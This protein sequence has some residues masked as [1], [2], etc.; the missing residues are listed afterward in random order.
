MA[1][2]VSTQVFVPEIFDGVHARGTV[3]R[4]V[5]YP[6]EPVAANELLFE[7]R[8]ADTCAEILAPFAGTVLKIHA[9]EGDAVQAGTLL[10]HIR[11]A[12]GAATFTISG[13]IR[14]TVATR[15]PQTAAM[16][17]AAG[18]LV[19]PKL[20]LV[21]VL[22]GAITVL[23]ARTADVRR[24]DLRRR[25]L[26]VALGHLL[27]GTG[28]WA[29]WSVR[30]PWRVRRLC[31]R[32]VGLG[33]LAIALSTALGALLWLIEEGPNGVL[34]AARI[35]VVDHAGRAFAFFACAW[36]LYGFLA[37]PEPANAL[38]D[39]ARSSPAWANVAG[40]AAALIVVLLSA[41]LPNPSGSVTAVVADLRF[42][43]DAAR[44]WLE[45]RRADWVLSEVRAVGRCLRARGRGGWRRAAARTRDDGSVVVSVYSRRR[46]PSGN[47]SLGTLM[48]AL[49]NQLEPQNVTVVLHVLRPRG[50]LRFRTTATARPLRRVRSIAEGAVATGSVAEYLAGGAAMT[51]RDRR[52][53]LRCSAPLL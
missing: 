8:S 20:W 26:S 50:R 46:Q 13:Q 24:G 44:Q 39:V 38:R 45:V 17:L 11:P 4:S 32:T 1:D 49:Q 42:L 15:A 3:T 19:L 16:A 36:L 28:R 40:V 14:R 41:V 21:M 27:L 48:L 10:T 37:R 6:G 12:V 33:I 23:G 22:L 7:V 18:A 53:A 2:S 34:A 5:K 30:T 43:P 51:A 52:I 47:R 9:G 29:L 35:A 25:R 31:L